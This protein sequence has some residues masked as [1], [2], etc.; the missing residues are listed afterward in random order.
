MTEKKYILYDFS[1]T[2][3]SISFEEHTAYVPC[4]EGSLSFLFNIDTW[5]CAAETGFYCHDSKK[6]SN[7]HESV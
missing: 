7:E 2:S 6:E 4:W 5:L 1:V 3:V